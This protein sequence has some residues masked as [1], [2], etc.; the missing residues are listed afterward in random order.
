M[1]Q[2]RPGGHLRLCGGRRGQGEMDAAV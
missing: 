2:A 1:P